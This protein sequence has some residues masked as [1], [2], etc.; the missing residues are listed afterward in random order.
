VAAND[1]K[2]PEYWL[3]EAQARGRGAELRSSCTKNSLLH[4]KLRFESLDGEG[5]DV[6]PPGERKGDRLLLIA[7]S[8]SDRRLL[9]LL[10]LSF[11]E[12]HTATLAPEKFWPPRNSGTREIL[13]PGEC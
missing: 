13:A 10:A 3:H 1:V 8:S 9:L 6:V 2:R 7:L 12:L 5:A 11:Q 4:P